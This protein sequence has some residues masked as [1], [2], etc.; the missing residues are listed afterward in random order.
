[1]KHA[2]DDSSIELG[3]SD[4]EQEFPGGVVKRGVPCG[5]RCTALRN[6]N[7]HPLSGACQQH[8]VGIQPIALSVFTPDLLPA[9]SFEA[10]KAPTRGLM[11][12]VSVPYHCSPVEFQSLDVK[13]A[14]SVFQIVGGTYIRWTVEEPVA[15]I[16]LHIHVDAHGFDALGP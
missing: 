1:M 10:A 3:K 15:R 5:V 9:G 14:G 4:G 7:D 16:N 13:L 6:H 11:H 2:Q 8:P 12:Q